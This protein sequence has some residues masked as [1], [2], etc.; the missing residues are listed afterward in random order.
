MQM[1]QVGMA[2]NVSSTRVH[3][4]EKAAIQRLKQLD[5]LAGLEDFQSLAYGA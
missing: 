1:L 4:L 2:L 5:A 3:Q